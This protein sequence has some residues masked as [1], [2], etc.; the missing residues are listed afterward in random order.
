MA[1]GRGT[2]FPRMK[3]YFLQPPTVAQESAQLVKPWDRDAL[4]PRSDAERTG[5][6]AL[7]KFSDA[8]TARGRRQ[9]EQPRRPLHA[10]DALRVR[11]LIVG[12]TGGWRL[13]TEFK[14][15]QTPT[16]HGPRACLTDVS[17]GWV[18]RS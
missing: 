14:S 1:A 5:R 2:P 9:R 10:V 7:R 8:V 18:A 6:S 15:Q 13:G 16:D 4:P 12:I 11:T 17:A 3:R